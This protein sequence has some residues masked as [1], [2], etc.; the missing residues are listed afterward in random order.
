MGN[1]RATG[2]IQHISAVTLAV[3]DMVR[4]IEF[5]RKLGFELVYGAEGVGFSSLKTGESFVNLVASPVYEPKWWGRVIFRVDDVDAH[6]R[7]L[8]AQGLAIESPR[9]APWGERFFHV[10]DP[11][12][13]ELSFAELLPAQS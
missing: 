1:R 2:M 13:H 8:R 5:Y 6:Y 11:D 9:D 4:S 7:T 10:L 12:G 3:R